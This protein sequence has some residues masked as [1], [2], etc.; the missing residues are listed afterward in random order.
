MSENEKLD[1]G[2]DQETAPAPGKPAKAE[3]AEKPK[4]DKAAKPKGKDKKPG[5]FA[6]IAKWFRE[7]R[8]ELKKVQWPTA[9]QTANN[10]IIVII[11][12]IVVGICIWI[13]DAIAGGIVDAL[14]NLFGKG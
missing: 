12:V 14:L 5:F 7:M 2:M 11:C 13:F 1:Q 9:K 4:K 3:K 8:S 6:R 10:V